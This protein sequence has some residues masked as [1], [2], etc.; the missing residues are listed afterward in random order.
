MKKISLLS[1]VAAC[2][3]YAGGYKIPETSLNGVALSAAN[4]AHTTGAD[5]AY[6]NPANMV[7][8]EDR[9]TLEFD[10]M[11][12]GLQGTKFEG[13]G[14][15]NG[16]NIEAE[17]ELFLI[18]SINYV[19]GKAGE[20]RIGLSICVPGGLT[21]RWESAPAVY[22]AEQFSL[23]VIEIN[24]TVAIPIG[25]TLSV[26]IG[27]RIV[28]SEGIVKSTSSLASRD[29]EGESWDFG[30]NLALSYKPIKSLDMALTYR[31]NVD[32]T[33]EGTAKLFQG[34][35][36]TYD[37]GSS[38]TVPLPALFNAAIAYTFPSETTLEFVYER[39]FWSAYKT[40]EFNYVGN[41]GNLEPVFGTPIAKNWKDTNAYRIGVTQEIS[42]FTLMFGAV[43]DETPVPDET[44]SFE[45][46]DSDSISVS[47]G[48]RYQINDDW[49]IGI[50]AL[51]SMRDTRTVAN[52]DISGEFS[53]SNVLILSAGVEY[54][55]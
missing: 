22:S 28:H 26:A 37:G 53:N 11:F 38:V 55:F 1:L 2:S 48:G 9:N 15:M 36:L 34:R 16:V 41:I 27:F 52:E 5:A 25:D 49:N 19:S 46:P 54:K 45:L 44:V 30:Y 18:P 10:N 21:K 33:E 4:V 51:Y 31:S 43:I 35:N 12:I 7:F 29:M 6:Y 47:A 8:M 3:L 32:L 13:S 20:T 14:P 42:D 17:S 23:S 40:L 50:A 39:N 24:P